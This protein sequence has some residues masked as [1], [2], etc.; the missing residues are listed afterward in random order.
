[1]NTSDNNLINFAA[2]MSENTEKSTF[3]GINSEKKTISAFDGS[4]DDILHL[5]REVL[6]EAVDRLREE[7]KD[8]DSVYTYLN[9]LLYDVV[10]S[11]YDIY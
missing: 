4:N 1:M 9:H 11:K 10:Q 6:K 7:L 8:K 5:Y 2:S 3:A